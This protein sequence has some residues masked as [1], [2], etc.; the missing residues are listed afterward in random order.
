VA[1]E[2]LGKYTDQS[3]VFT[4]DDETNNQ[5]SPEPGEPTDPSES[6]I[7]HRS[8]R[9]ARGKASSSGGKAGKKFQIDIFRD[10]CK[11][12]GICSAFCPKGCIRMNEDG[13]PEIV[14]GTQCSGCGWCEVHCPDFA[15]SVREYKPKKNSMDECP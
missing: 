8:S 14:E 15:V 3:E 11:N 6:Q 13:V 10:W 2:C 1:L 5:R 4:M 7:S 9:S 12:C